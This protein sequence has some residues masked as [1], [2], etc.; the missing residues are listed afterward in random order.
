MQK[1]VIVG[2]AIAVGVGVGIVGVVAARGLTAQAVAV[3]VHQRREALVPGQR[4][5]PL[6][7]TR[8]G[9]ESIQGGR[10]DVK[11][12]LFT[13]IHRKAVPLPAQMALGEREGEP[14]RLE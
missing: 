2:E 3:G 13:H 11:L 8:K 7:L 4:V 10:E 1:F 14:W 5:T 6:A 12:E 9:V